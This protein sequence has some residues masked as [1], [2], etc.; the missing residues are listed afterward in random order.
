MFFINAKYEGTN[1]WWQYMLTIIFVAFG[2]I[3]GSLPFTVAVAIGIRNTHPEFSAAQTQEFIKSMDF[4]GLDIDSNLLLVL[5]LLQFVFGLGFLYL[6][7]RTLHKKRF[8]SLISAWNR[9]KWKKILR[10]F[11]IW[12]GLLALFELINYWMNPGNY[13]W[14]Y[15]PATF[16]T[17]LAIAIF[18]IPLQTSL[19]EIFIR[20]YI[21]QGL[22]IAFKNRW[23]PILISSLIFMA[24]HGANPEIAAFGVYKMLTYYFLVGFFFAVITVM[25]DGL[26]IPLGFHAANNIF[27]A[28][29]LTFKGSTLQTEALFIS[30]DA[31]TDGMILSTIIIFLIIMIAAHKLL[32]WGD[33]S[34]LWSRIDFQTIK[35][36]IAEL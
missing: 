20:G 1:D 29:I 15:R 35:N 22:G 16:F 18:I 17:L 4:S 32:K 7:V 31:N 21:M 8:E 10:S 3:L 27:S 23:A 5:M 6:M 25:D 11:W 24:L 30:K 14:N 33:W 13:I 2:M 12:F 19:E 36:D 9:V 26:E 28:V 34:K